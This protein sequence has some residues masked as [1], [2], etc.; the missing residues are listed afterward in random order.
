MKLPIEEFDPSRRNVRRNDV[1]VSHAR[2][3]DLLQ[4]Q[5]N[6]EEALASFQASHVIRQ[7]LAEYDLQ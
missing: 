4:E 3:G 2:I 7:R 1:A 6:L 5:G